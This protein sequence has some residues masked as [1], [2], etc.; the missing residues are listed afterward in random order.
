MKTINIDFTDSTVGNVGRAGEHNNT[1]I[2]F[3]LSPE[4]AKCDFLTAE[5]GT[6]A[7][8]KIPIEGTYNEENSTFSILLTNQLTVEGA[9]SFQLVGYVTECDT[10]EPQII[11]KSPVVS[12]FITQGIN[13]IEAEAD[14]NP[15]LLARIWAKI[16]EWADKIHT[17][18]NKDTLDKLGESGE[19]LTYDGKKVVDSSVLAV[20]KEQKQLESLSD[21][22]LLCYVLT[23]RIGFVP[24]TLEAG[25]VYGGIEKYQD[26]DAI[27]IDPLLQNFFP[28]SAFTVTTEKVLFD[29][30][31]NMYC[32][33]E[34]STDGSTYFCKKRYNDD[35]LNTIM[36]Y[37][38]TN[39]SIIVDDITFPVGWGK[40]SVGDTEVMEIPIF[41]DSDYYMYFDV[42]SLKFSNDDYFN[43]LQ[44]V[45]SDERTYGSVR[46]YYQYYNF[47]WQKID[48]G[49]MSIIS[50]SA[51][52]SVDPTLSTE[53]AAADA[54]ATGDRFAEHYTKQEID[55][56]GFITKADIPTD[57]SY[58]ILGQTPLTLDETSNIKLVAEG[59]T[60]YSIETPTV[61]NFD[62][63][64]D[65]SA[66]CTLEKVDGYYKVTADATATK[67][68]QP[69][70]V[71][72]V[73][74]LKI[75]ETYTLTWDVS[76]SNKIKGNSTTPSDWGGVIVLYSG[77]SI[78]SIIKSG[79]VLDDN[80]SYSF[81]A[82]DTILQ[83]RYH[84]TYSEA[85][86]A[87]SIGRFNTLYLNKGTST[88]LTMPYKNSGT[89]T[90]T[91][92][93][94]AIPSSATIT[95]APTADVYIKAPTDKTLTKSDVPADAKETGERIE[96]VKNLLPLY[97]KTIVNFGDSI[98]GNQQP[99]NDI[100]TFLAEKTGATVYN[101]GF[102][103]CRMT[104]HP[105]TEYDAFCMYNLA[106]AI[107]TRDF[108]KQNEAV[109]SG[110]LA[111][112]YSVGLERL[113]SIDF[114]KV[115]IVTVA[116][117]TNDFNGYGVNLD[118]EENPLEIN[119]FGGA[120]RYS[121]EKL[122]TAYPNLKIFVL[123]IAYRFWI[124]DNNEFTEDSNTRVN[125]ISLKL[126]DYNAKL[127]EV[128][129]EYNLPYVDDYNIGIGKF[130]RY[131]YFNA[132]DGAHHK[133]TGRRLIAEHLAS[134][135][136]IGQSHSDSYTIW[137]AINEI[138]GGFDEIE[139][140]IDESGVLD[141]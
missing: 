122:L 120:L 124:D 33:Y 54:K 96:A 91:A 11:T 31:R 106:D 92:T 20:V 22:S 67:W 126:G 30:G 79:L 1:K 89:F 118:N 61:W 65:S 123:S 86:I 59:E 2:I 34:F 85:L 3:A 137:K 77:E 47:R 70:M 10:A 80:V 130:N 100:S 110:N 98:F 46:G 101:C 49:R 90:D 84:P 45:F 87:N 76:S 16:R 95:T 52:L 64:Y 21:K 139:A 36:L 135:L 13:G 127:K 27:Y 112:R 78:S 40:Y 18:A 93:F 39:N 66:L 41:T 19:I 133:E 53:G 73:R 7:G 99:P 14:S 32:H 109:A 35:E 115:D 5:V 4:L 116:Y 57:E 117:G 43:E 141:E 25:V 104:P 37:N 74:N 125:S 88:E 58:E 42:H 111:E 68:Y 136:T 44:K 102:G 97:G 56:K 62:G 48:F 103:G 60:T 17:H 51:P 63:T 69:Y 81:T 23:D 8:D 129:E 132:N 114:S 94:K 82:T 105:T 15:N 12:G 28:C 24:V 121:I 72:F 134:A 113:K 71:L 138:K 50:N 9:I 75:G 119:T 107:T 55:D 26:R 6:A 128:A 38:A 140:M 83:I 108:A 29:E 131:Q